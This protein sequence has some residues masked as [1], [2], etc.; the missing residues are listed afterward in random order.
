MPKC[1]SLIAKAQL[2]LLS[3]RGG[4]SLASL[5]KL[6]VRASCIGGFCLVDTWT[7][8]NRMETT[9]TT[10]VV[11]QKNQTGLVKREENLAVA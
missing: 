2:L 7:S 5:M 6:L 9:G 11:G 4:Q 3:L 1:R 10:N 8:G